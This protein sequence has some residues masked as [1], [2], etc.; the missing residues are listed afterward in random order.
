[1]RNQVDWLAPLVP[2]DKL[3]AICASGPYRAF[4]ERLH[5]RAYTRPL[6]VAANEASKGLNWPAPVLRF[7]THTALWRL[8]VDADLLRPL[9]ML[10]PLQ[11]GG[12]AARVTLRKNIFGEMSW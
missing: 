6:K 12:R 7:C 11:P 1:M 9:C 10:E 4:I 5:E 8:D 3:N 2:R